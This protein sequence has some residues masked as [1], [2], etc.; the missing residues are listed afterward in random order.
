[1]PLKKRRSTR[2]TLSVEDVYRHCAEHFQ[3]TPQQVDK[4]EL[5]QWIAMNAGEDISEAELEAFG[6]QKTK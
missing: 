1:V 6:L 2:N 3:W 4:I 5:T